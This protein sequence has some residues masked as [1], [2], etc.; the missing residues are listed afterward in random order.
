ME[1]EEPEG[2]CCRIP[3]GQVGV[4]V[5]GGGGN[6]PGV[7]VVYEGVVFGVGLVW[8]L[9]PKVPGYMGWGRGGVG[10]PLE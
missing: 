10:K 3:C 6:D 4:W 8:E 2:C 5:W 1:G 7:D 9:V